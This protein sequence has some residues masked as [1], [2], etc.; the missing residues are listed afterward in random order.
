MFLQSE[1]L[2]ALNWIDYTLLAVLLAFIVTG[3][4]K[5]FVRQVLQIAGIVA[6]FFLAARFTPAAARLKLFDGLR[7]HNADAPYVISYIALFTA[8]AAAASVLVHLWARWFSSQKTL[9]PADSLFGG[10]LGGVK[11]VLLLGGVCIGL[12]EWKG[13]EE[14]AA[15]KQ[16]VIAPKMAEGCRSL[17]FLIPED[18]RQEIQEFNQAAREK[19]KSH[20][21][22]GILHLDPGA[23]P[24]GPGAVP[25]PPQGAGLGGTEKKSSALDSR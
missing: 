18:E 6:A 13:I 4:L 12:L 10:L 3:Y 1:T 19:I 15:F 23:S 5:G 20:L 14:V 8:A 21:P 24:E 16:S 25:A 11:G 22:P 9:R 7:Q 17:V 2:L